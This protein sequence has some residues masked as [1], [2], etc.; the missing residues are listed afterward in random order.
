[1]EIRIK[2][3]SPVLQGTWPTTPHP[4]YARA[5]HEQYKPSTNFSPTPPWTSRK[6]YWPMP[7]GTSTPQSLCAIF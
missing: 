6:N 4:P 7:L 2:R 1:M 3:L 5:P